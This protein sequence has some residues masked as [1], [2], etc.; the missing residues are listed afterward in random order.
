MD[1]QEKLQNIR[2]EVK[3]LSEWDM[4]SITEPH[5]DYPSKKIQIFEILADLDD[6]LNDL[7]DEQ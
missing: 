7:G 2:N 3:H 5:S 4:L 6:V 1:I